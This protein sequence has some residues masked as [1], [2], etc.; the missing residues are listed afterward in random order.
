MPM[1]AAEAVITSVVIRCGILEKET[2]KKKNPKES[3]ASVMV[4]M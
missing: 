2:R 4:E 1:R 3:L